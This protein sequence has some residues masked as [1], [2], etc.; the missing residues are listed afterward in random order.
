MNPLDVYVEY[1]TM[2]F[3]GLTSG[4]LQHPHWT[5]NNVPKIKN[6]NLNTSIFNSEAN[7]LNSSKG[8]PRKNMQGAEIY[9]IFL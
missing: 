1:K 8:S 9:I 7:P 5:K 3:P 4:V 2:V 6:L